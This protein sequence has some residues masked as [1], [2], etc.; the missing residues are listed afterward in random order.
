MW[1]YFS[2]STSRKQPR[3]PS[4]PGPLLLYL[5][6]FYFSSFPHSFV[7]PLLFIGLYFL[8]LFLRA[9]NCRDR[10]GCLDP[11]YYPSIFV[12]PLFPIPLLPHCY[13]LHCFVFPPPFPASRKQPRP[14]WLPGTLLLPICFVIFLLTP[15]P[16]LP[17]YYTLVSVFLPFFCG[18]QNCRY[19]H[20][21]LEPY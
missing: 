6:V 15:N 21:C 13:T 11:C 8:R 3:P 9:A 10:H 20:S 19:L 17:R 7:T 1:A 14:P 5:L 4:L 16:S 12:F 18:P 2:R